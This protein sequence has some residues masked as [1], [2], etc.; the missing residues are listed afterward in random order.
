MKAIYPNSIRRVMPQAMRFA[1]MLIFL[2]PLSVSAQ[3]DNV[4][5]T[6]ASAVP[7]KVEDYSGNRDGGGMQSAVP[8][9]KMWPLSR[10]L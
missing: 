8:E 6:A 5:G 9:R 10:K 4:L 3:T 7:Q 2:A 1:T